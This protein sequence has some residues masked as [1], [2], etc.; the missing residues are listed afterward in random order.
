MRNRHDS[1]CRDRSEGN[2]QSLIGEE[3]RFLHA[4][5]RDG[6]ITDETRRR[7]ELDL[8]LEEASIGNR[9]QDGGVL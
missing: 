9:H 5:L 1:F 7:I 2:R 6:K 4:Q 8:D 3:R